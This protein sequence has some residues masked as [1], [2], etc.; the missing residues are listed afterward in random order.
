MNMES[1]QEQTV[2]KERKASI[3]QVAATMFWALFMIGRK[4]TWEREGAVITLPQ[5]IVG[6]VLGVVVLIATLMLIV[7]LVLP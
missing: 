3:G 4:G 2:R 5:A 7:S 1:K 6:G